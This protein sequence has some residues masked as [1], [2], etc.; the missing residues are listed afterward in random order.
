V[1]TLINAKEL[2]RR[3]PE[4]VRRVKQGTRF[5]VLYRSRPAFEIVPV[6][7]ASVPQDNLENDSLY[8]APA[9]GRSRDGLS[10]RDHDAVLY[11]K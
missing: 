4:I 1:S 6:D 5:T 3:L 8:R 2:W 11:G 9:L 7:A 10:A